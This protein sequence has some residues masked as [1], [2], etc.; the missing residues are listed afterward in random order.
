MVFRS[1]AESSSEIFRDS[2]VDD[3]EVSNLGRV[4]RISTGR[5]LAPYRRA[6][7]HVQVTLWDQGIRRT[8]YVPK[9]VWEAFNGPLQP[10]QR[11]AHMNGDR[12]D[13]RL[14]NLFLETH[15][16][17]MKRAWDAKRRKWESIYQGV[18]W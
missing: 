3:V 2:V 16:D 7:G 13:N 5:I 15:S 11:I 1:T 6:N 4:R 14:S 12:T 10:L 9:L 17:S 8:K 18:L